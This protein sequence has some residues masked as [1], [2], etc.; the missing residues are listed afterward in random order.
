MSNPTTSSSAKDSPGPF[1]LPKDTPES[2]PHSSSPATGL[3]KDNQFR[4]DIRHGHLL[5]RP[6][7]TLALL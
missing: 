7:I 6:T 2:S 5:D 1:P 4:T 3:T